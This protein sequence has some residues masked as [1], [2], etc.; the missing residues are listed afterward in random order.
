MPTHTETSS[1]KNIFKLFA[2][3]PPFLNQN[4]QLRISSS[5]HFVVKFY[6]LPAH[7]HSLPVLC[8]FKWMRVWTLHNKQRQHFVVI[9][10]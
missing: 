6:D 5:H 9:H 3:R 1:Q 7:H 2:V 4:Q 10:G 8:G